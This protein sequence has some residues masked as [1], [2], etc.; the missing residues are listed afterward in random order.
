[1]RGEFADVAAAGEEDIEGLLIVVQ[2]AAA[3]SAGG[4]NDPAHQTEGEDA[5]RDQAEG[6]EH[7]KLEP[8][9][10]RSF[11]DFARAVVLR[12]TRIGWLEKSRRRRSMRTV[13]CRWQVD[14]LG[15]GGGG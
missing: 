12:R 10:G 6:G 1:M 3:E 13:R 15:P 4:Q 7:E 8:I 5:D 9:G 2:K 11:V 14:Q